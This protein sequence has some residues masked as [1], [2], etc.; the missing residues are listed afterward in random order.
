MQRIYL[1][2]VDGTL[3]PPRQRIDEDFAAIFLEWRQYVGA[4]VY[5]VTGSSLKVIKKQIFDEFLQACDGVF[6]CSGNE[7]WQGKDLIYR[8]KFRVPSGLLADLQ[9]YLSTGARYHVRTGRHI[10]RRPGMINFS[11]LG[12]NANLLHREA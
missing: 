11:V 12:R 5:L 2:D 9:L 1:F 4:P 6:T 8:R 10:A 7:L 3:T